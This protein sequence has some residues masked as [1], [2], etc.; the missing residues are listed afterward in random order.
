MA[1][2]TRRPFAHSLALLVVVVA[3]ATDARA[4]DGEPPTPDKL[5]KQRLDWHAEIAR[6]E[7][8]DDEAKRLVQARGGVTRNAAN[9]TVLKQLGPVLSENYKSAKNAGQKLVEAAEARRNETQKEWEEVYRQRIAFRQYTDAQQKI[10]KFDFD[11][12]AQPGFQ[13]EIFDA[14]VIVWAAVLFVIAVRLSKKVRRVELRRLERA[15]SV[16]L[17][18]GLLSA[19]GCAGGAASADGRPWIVREEA[20]LTSDLKEAKKK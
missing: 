1:D 10:Y 6:Q 19:S 15:A 17:L 9:D 16:L 13:P 5:V 8:A 7:T 2:S 14:A 18:A 20:K 11:T 12:G 3:L 4:Q